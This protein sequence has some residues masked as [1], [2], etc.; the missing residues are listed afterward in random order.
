MKHVSID[1]LGLNEVRWS[2]A[3][4]FHM[5]LSSIVYSDGCGGQVGVAIVLQDV[6]K[7]S[8]ISYS[9]V[10]NRIVVQCTSRMSL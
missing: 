4:H 6:S 2:D 5:N 9:T 10:S 8:L 3:G 1:V 7:R